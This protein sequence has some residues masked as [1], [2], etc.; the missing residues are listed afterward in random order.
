[1]ITDNIPVFDKYKPPNERTSDYLQLCNI[2]R[3]IT[4]FKAVITLNQALLLIEYQRGLIIE[5]SDE[6]EEMYKQSVPYG[7]PISFYTDWVIT[8][9]DIKK[10][11]ID[12]SQ[13]I[14][15]TTYQRELKVIE[16]IKTAIGGCNYETL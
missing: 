14:S 3:A 15:F 6:L 9:T 12:D 1:M 4:E 8:E 2:C 5:L 7:K 16:K 10:L 11:D 13:I